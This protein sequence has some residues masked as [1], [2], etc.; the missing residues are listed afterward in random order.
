MA[1]TCGEALA[2]ALGHARALVQLL[3]GL[4]GAALAPGA[5]ADD[6]RALA[7]AIE[8]TVTDAARSGTP[9]GASTSIY[10]ALEAVD[11]LRMAAAGN[12]LNLMRAAA[13]GIEDHL[14]QACNLA[15]PGG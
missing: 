14:A 12:D 3:D 15:A 6:A 5:A 1:D 11:S 9:P 2:A 13:H 7:D 8:R 4:D 10:Q